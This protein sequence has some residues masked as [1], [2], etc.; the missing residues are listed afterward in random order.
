MQE[1]R[2]LYGPVHLQAKRPS[3]LDRLWSNSHWGLSIQ[4]LP[5][6]LEAAGYNAHRSVSARERREQI[7]DVKGKN[8]E[9]RDACA[10]RYNRRLYRKMLLDTY[11]QTIR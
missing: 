7:R 5:L 8:E 1:R 9:R 10:I 3:H 2:V 6:L 11:R 4:L